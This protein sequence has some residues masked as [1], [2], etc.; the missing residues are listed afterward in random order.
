MQIL[1]HSPDPEFWSDV[2]CGRPIAIFH[3]YGRWHVY[4]D[5]VLQ[6]NVVFAT[7]KDALAWLVKRIDQGV[8]A[9]LN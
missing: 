2:Y 1:A 6:H 4:L 8:P 9:R 5:H 7:G 3:R